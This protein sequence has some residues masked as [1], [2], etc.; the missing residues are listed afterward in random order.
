MLHVLF[1]LVLSLLAAAQLERS[2][3]FAAPHSIRCDRRLPAWAPALTAAETRGSAVGLARGPSTRAGFVLT[4]PTRLA[5]LGLKG[6]TSTPV[7]FLP[8][9]SRT[10]HARTSRS[11]PAGEQGAG[12]DRCAS[13]GERRGFS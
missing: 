2:P 3:A 5:G 7:R 8:A 6:A 4:S 9:P 11:S 1:L 12:A 10:S 13:V